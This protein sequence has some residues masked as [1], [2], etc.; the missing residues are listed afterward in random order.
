MKNGKF[1]T[2]SIS[3]SMGSPSSMPWNDLYGT[4]R[5]LLPGQMYIPI[6]MTT[7]LFGSSVHWA[8][9]GGTRRRYLKTGVITGIF[10]IGRISRNATK[11]GRGLIIHAHTPSLAVVLWVA[12]FLNPNV[13]LVHTIHNEWGK[14]STLQKLWLRLLCS[15]SKQSICCGDAVYDTVPGIVRQKLTMRNAICVVPNGIRSDAL[16]KSHPISNLQRD[17]RSNVVVVA[18]M[19]PQKNVSAIIDIFTKLKNANKL[20]WFGDGA[21]RSTV[22][23]AIRNEN[24]DDRVV[25]MGNRPREE[26]LN[27]LSQSSIYLSCSLWE[28]LSVADLEA[29]ALGC[30][31]FMSR[32]PQHDEIAKQLDFATYPLEDYR[33]WISD[34]DEFLLQ[35]TVFRQAITKAMAKKTRHIFDLNCSVDRYGRIYAEL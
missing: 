29:C 18:R 21:K 1:W 8:D 33:L 32:I 4:A 12:L 27:E 7:R 30:M 3:K 16:N 25:L 28:G 20:I 17:R 9:C 11:K 22:E 13:S 19:V 15:I 26:V 10:Q 14:F 24:I 34:I 2:L 31:P 35:D 5:T 6:S 23:E